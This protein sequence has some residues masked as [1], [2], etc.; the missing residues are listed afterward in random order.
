[1]G[2]GERK[3]PQGRATNRGKEEEMRKN[4]RDV[5]GNGGRGWDGLNC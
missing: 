5:K 3:I 4:V 1:M 2:R